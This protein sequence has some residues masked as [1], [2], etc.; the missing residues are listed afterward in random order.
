MC[1]LS[2]RLRICPLENEYDLWLE[3]CIFRTLTSHVMICPELEPV[4][5]SPGEERGDD[6]VSQMTCILKLYSDDSLENP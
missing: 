4:V 3:G 6:K 1:L 5:S 2:V